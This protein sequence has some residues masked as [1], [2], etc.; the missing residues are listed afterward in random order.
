MDKHTQKTADESKKE[1]NL[2]ADTATAGC[3]AVNWTNLLLS[4]FFIVYGPVRRGGG[5]DRAQG[6][7]RE[8]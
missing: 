4:S 7:E 8:R 6:K 5:G 2:I 1:I 3:K